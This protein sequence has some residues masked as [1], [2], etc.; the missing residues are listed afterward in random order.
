MLWY[1][2]WLETRWRFLIG[3]AL[4][5]LSACGTVLTYPQVVQLLPLAPQ[6]DVGGEI[7]RRVAEAM[8]AGARLPRLRMVAVVPPEHAAEMDALRRVARNRRHAL[9][10]LR[11]RRRCSRCRCRFRAAACSAS[12][13][14]PAWR[15]CWCWR[16][17]PR[18]CCRCFRRPSGKRYGLGDA[19]VHALCMFVAG[20]VFFSLRFCSPLCSPMCGG[21]C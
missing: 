11:W 1:K 21:R 8:R 13:P 5:I 2:S 19:L 15:N 9:A 20:T 10:N 17:S 18:S 14:R 3:L 4:L 6:V 7:G 12:A 16:S